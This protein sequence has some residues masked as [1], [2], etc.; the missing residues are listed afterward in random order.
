[1][2]KQ[3]HINFYYQCMGTGYLPNKSSGDNTGLCGAAIHGQIS[4]SLLNL[5][6]PTSNEADELI[7][8]YSS[9]GW[10]GYEGNIFDCS[11]NEDRNYKFTTLRQTIILFM[12]CMAGE[13]F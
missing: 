2:K 4:K 9:T 13:K 3:Q 8:N 11:H 12:A 1:M 6:E 7:P 5:F 10:W